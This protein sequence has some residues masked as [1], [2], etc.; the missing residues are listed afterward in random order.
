VTLE[1]ISSTKIQIGIK[2]HLNQVSLDI[3]SNYAT[4]TPPDTFSGVLAF[5]NY[6]TKVLQI[7]I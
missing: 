3:S 4:R 2:P 7:F 6:P 1:V 5:G